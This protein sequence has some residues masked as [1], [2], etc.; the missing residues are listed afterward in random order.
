[1]GN[2]SGLVGT[3]SFWNVT[4]SGLATSAGGTGLTSS[5]MDT[6]ANFISA[7]WNFTSI[8][9]MP[10]GSYPLLQPTASP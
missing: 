6:Q 5:Q 2:N 9:Y 4:T 8:W 7:G 3:S 10:S 1:V